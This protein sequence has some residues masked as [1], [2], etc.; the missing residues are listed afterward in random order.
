[1]TH[2]VLT[3]YPAYTLAALSFSLS[4]LAGLCQPARAA[5]DDPIE[6]VRIRTVPVTPPA[7]LQVPEPGTLALVGVGLVG[8]VLRRR[9]KG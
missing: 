1:M 8:M 3:R 9:F 5:A 6:D 4:L 2:A 7:Q